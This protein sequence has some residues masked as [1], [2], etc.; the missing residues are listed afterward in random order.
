MK[1]IAK[2]RFAYYMTILVYLGLIIYAVISLIYIVIT[3]GFDGALVILSCIQLV[4]FYLI[5][6]F[7]RKHKD[8]YI[9]F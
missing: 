8:K 4:I 2:K 7:I 5:I 1:Y 9:C 6:H 3:T